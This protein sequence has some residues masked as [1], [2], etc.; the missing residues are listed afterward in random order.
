MVAG[1]ATRF[2]LGN[3][4]IVVAA[5]LVVTGYGFSFRGRCVRRCR[6]LILGVI[7][8][9]GE[10]TFDDNCCI[11]VVEIVDIV[12]LLALGAL[13]SVCDGFCGAGVAVDASFVPHLS[14]ACCSRPIWSAFGGGVHLRETYVANVWRVIASFS[15]MTC[16]KRVAVGCIGAL[17][18]D[19]ISGAEPHDRKK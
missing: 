3:R 4:R 18:R 6:R 5:I 11:P 16:Q 15:H 8:I 2:S 13:E 10:E 1:V 14:T 12:F 7:V 19:A 17:D 9:L